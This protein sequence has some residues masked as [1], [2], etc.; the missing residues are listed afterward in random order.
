MSFNGYFEGKRVLVTGH[1]GFKGSWLCAW[2]LDLGAT[3]AGVSKDIP[4]DPA[5]FEIL[6]LS[7][8]LMD[9][10]VDIRS[11][12]S[13]KAIFDRF[14]PQ[15]VFHLAAQPIV[16]LAYENPVQT[17]GSNVMGTLHVLEAVRSSNSVESVLM[18][19]SDKCYDN[20]EWCYG[21]REIDR[22]G[23]KDPYSASKA[24][25]ELLI[26]THWHSYLKESGVFLASARAGNVIGGGDWAPSRVVPDAM[27]AWYQDDSLYLRNPNATRPWQHVLEPLAGYLWLLADADGKTTAERLS[28]LPGKDGPFG[29]DRFKRHLVYNFGPED[30]ANHSVEQLIS[31]MAVLWPD[32]RWQVAAEHKGAH[33]AGLLK[34]NCDKARHEL[35]WWATLSFEETVAMTVAWYKANLQHSSSGMHEFTLEQIHAYETMAKEKGLAWAL[36]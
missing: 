14:C 10:R 4:T 28:V 17:F 33:E 3:V 6:R 21:Y 9:Y 13:L 24:C 7:E 35:R 27:R 22:L 12:E 18:V 2:L 36:S 29:Q 19:T 16:A 1:T 31:S 34:L 8:R 25:A 15:V 5:I 23:G 20:V 26:E 32:R 30:G 11:Y